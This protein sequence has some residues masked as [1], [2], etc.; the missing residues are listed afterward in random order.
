MKQ[1]LK[2]VYTYT[3]VHILYFI[4]YMR[5]DMY[6]LA[7]GILLNCVLLDPPNLVFKLL[8]CGIVPLISSS[9]VMLIRSR[10]CEVQD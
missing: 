3:Y 7:F 10:S 4:V 2:K 9:L 6:T 8:S 5:I 1:P